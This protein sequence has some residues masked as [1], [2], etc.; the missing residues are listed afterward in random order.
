MESKSDDIV[1]DYMLS[2]VD[3]DEYSINDYRNGSAFIMNL[4]TQIKGRL[5]NQ[6]DNYEFLSR[7]YLIDQIGLNENELNNLKNKLTNEKI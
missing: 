2:F 7:K 6:D 1:K 3:I 5:I 4:F